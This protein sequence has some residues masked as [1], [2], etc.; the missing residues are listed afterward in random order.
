MRSGYTRG[1]AASPPRQVGPCNC[2]SRRIRTLDGPP[3][4]Q[5][6]LGVRNQGVQSC[7]EV[8]SGGA[9]RA[10][11]ESL[12]G[13]STPH[14]ATLLRAQTHQ[15]P[16][17]ATACT[18]SARRAQPGSA[19]LRRGAARRAEGAARSGHTLKA[20]KATAGQARHAMPRHCTRGRLR[21]HCMHSKR[22]GDPRHWGQSTCLFPTSLLKFAK[23]PET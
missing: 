9:Q 10:H 20:L 23:Q 13:P 18:A 21:G 1:A 8:H 16:T 19:E 11:L 22:S 7:G 12:C 4:A 17:R 5:Q 15:S 14:Q 3:R 6:A 2:A